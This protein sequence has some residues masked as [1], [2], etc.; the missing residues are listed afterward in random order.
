MA[1]YFPAT[2]RVCSQQRGVTQQLCFRLI[3][4]VSVRGTAAVGW[5]VCDTVLS[6]RREK[7]PNETFNLS[8]ILCSPRAVDALDY[9]ILVVDTPFHSL[10]SFKPPLH[11]LA[12]A[13]L[14]QYESLG[15]GKTAN[16][17]L[18]R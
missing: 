2:N 9:S 6:T 17:L 11:P 12:T 8:I 15:Q 18:L 4:D 7:D 3:S 1:V 5:G 16:D 14:R 13:E 10:A